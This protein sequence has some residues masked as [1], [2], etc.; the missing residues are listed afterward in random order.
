MVYVDVPIMQQPEAYIS[1]SWN[2][3][4]EDGVTVDEKTETFLKLCITAYENWVN[5]F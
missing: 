3:W 2:I 4:K 1:G 5:K